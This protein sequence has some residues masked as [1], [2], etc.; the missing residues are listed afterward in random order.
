MHYFQNFLLEFKPNF[1]SAMITLGLLVLFNPAV[2]AQSSIY[3]SAGEF[4]IQLTSLGTSYTALDRIP[5]NPETI[6]FATEVTTEPDVNAGLSGTLTFSKSNTGLSRD[7]VLKTLQP[8]AGFTYDDDEGGANYASFDRALSVGDIN[9]Y[10][11]DDW[12]FSSPAAMR[13]FGVIIADS[14]T[15]TPRTIILLDAGGL[16]L[17]RFSFTVENS[18]SQFVGVITEY[19]FYEVRFDESAAPD[20][21]DLAIKNLRV[22]AVGLGW[23]EDGYGADVDMTPDG[24]TM[25]VGATGYDAPGF[26]IVHDR[27]LGGVDEWGIITK[28]YA[29]NGVDD[30]GFGTSVA[31][32][33][34][35][36]RVIVGAPYKDTQNLA[37]SGAAFVYH[38]HAGGW[39]KWGLVAEF[40]SS[41][42]IGSI[43]AGDNFGF[44]VDIDGAGGQVIVGVPGFDNGDL[45]DSGIAFRYAYQ[46]N[47]WELDYIFQEVMVEGD[48]CG[49][50]VTI[51]N[52][53]YAAAVSC[54]LADEVVNQ[55]VAS[56]A[57][58]YTPRGL[59]IPY[60]SYSCSEARLRD[61][62]DGA[63]DTYVEA[64]PG[65]PTYT[66]I[67]RRFLNATTLG[68]SI[69]MDDNGTNLAVMDNRAYL[70]TYK[71]TSPINT[72]WGEFPQAEVP[73]SLV[74]ESI[75][76]ISADGNTVVVGS[77][78]EKDGAANIEIGVAAVHRYGEGALINPQIL[79]FTSFPFESL[80]GMY[81]GGSA[82]VN[83]DGSLI[84]VGYP[85]YNLSRER[86]LNRN[87][88]V[89]LYSRGAEDSRHDLTK[90]VRN[91]IILDA[92]PE[93][94]LCVP[95]K[96]QNGRVVLICL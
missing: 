72:D 2:N 91:S 8:G 69:A 17:E 29:P 22:G 47:A 37:D 41:T 61:S 27:D 25:V 20:G 83:H 56:L 50:S 95:I 76:A 39:N 26:A 68:R 28:L 54:P 73:E 11:D 79:R 44:D 62:N 19:D 94:E 7:Y 23:Y 14:N 32:S 82:A 49:R 55:C 85:A 80:S 65:S 66:E 57:C 35:G 45:L 78:R 89:N 15:A 96:A 59:C 71:K 21:D 81:F 90:I 53:G 92:P 33:D 31:I 51:S 30:D 40:E 38:R 5:T 36:N 13:S 42:A 10:E 84:A 24:K 64:T 4:E 6:V 67:N 74:D 18:I 46:G 70:A 77:P 43:G 93:D 87:G 1:G 75:V 16:E 12:S 58:R 86:Q 60:V 88:G 48:A 52:D 63:V 9:N 34:D 3:F